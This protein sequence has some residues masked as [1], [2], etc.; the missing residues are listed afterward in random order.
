MR[1]ELE[2]TFLF[3]RKEGFYP[4]HIPRHT[5]ADNI[6]CNPGTLKVEEYRRDGRHKVVWTQADSWLDDDCRDAQEIR[7]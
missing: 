5:L 2:T 1:K 3:T 4:I 7:L 6:K